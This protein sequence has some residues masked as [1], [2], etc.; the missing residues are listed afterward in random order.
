MG[1]DID[2]SG[3]RPLIGPIVFG[4]LLSGGCFILLKDIISAAF[5]F[6]VFTMLLI[7]GGFYYVQSKSRGDFIPIY[8]DTGI[9]IF[10]SLLNLNAVL[11]FV[12]FH[13]FYGSNPFTLGL[14]YPTPLPQSLIL[15]G[16]IIAAFA[17]FLFI[18]T[19]YSEIGSYL[20]S[21]LPDPPSDAGIRQQDVSGILFFLLSIGVAL[22]LLSFLA[23][24]IAIQ[25][26]L[27]PSVVISDISGSV[28]GNLFVLSYNYLFTILPLFFIIG[29]REYGSFGRTTAI[30]I[31]VVL[32]LFFSGHLSFVII[33]LLGLF[34]CYHLLYK[35]A[36]R[37]HFLTLFGG[38]VLVGI[39]G[40][41]YRTYARSSE[42]APIEIVLLA[43]QA[44]LVDLP[45]LFMRYVVA[46]MSHFES[47]LTVKYFVDSGQAPLRFGTMYFDFLG[48]LI[49]FGGVSYFSGGHYTDILYVNNAPASLA[50]QIPEHY[51]ASIGALGEWYLNFHIVGIVMGTILMA[52]VFRIWNDTLSSNI[53]NVW[54]VSFHATNIWFIYRF[55][56]FNSRIIRS[57]L[58]HSIFFIMIFT[59]VRYY[60]H[61][62]YATAGNE[63]LAPE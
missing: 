34:A 40:K 52:V 36:T 11:L 25:D 15:E 56:A 21:R 6:L 53:D 54:V 58:L 46:R 31:V 62:R 27:T 49:P 63:A 9:A 43:G 16:V 24:G 14:Y 61:R 18:V 20:H 48:K 28:G 50:G 23:A 4:L 2:T 3:T 1:S 60:Q 51:T 12:R 45:V 10:F 47:F 57:L 19:F 38:F 13:R 33:P 59:T 32:L 39:G 44:I 41:I 26:I 37:G 30:T 5:V 35:R 55:W 22:Y 8:P 42:L 29:A 7:N 17:N